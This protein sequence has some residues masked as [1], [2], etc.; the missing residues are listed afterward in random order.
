MKSIVFEKPRCE[1]CGSTNVRARI[2]GDIVCIK[3][4]HVTKKKEHFEK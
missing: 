3:C 1:R 4:S 2:N